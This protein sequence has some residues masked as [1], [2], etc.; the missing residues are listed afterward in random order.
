MSMRKRAGY[1]AAAYSLDK[2]EV[3][4]A[5]AHGLR[6]EDDVGKETLREWTIAH[7]FQ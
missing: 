6:E 1:S 5:V 4:G 2:K 7:P 3:L